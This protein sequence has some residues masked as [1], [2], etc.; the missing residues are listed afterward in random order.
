MTMVVAW[1]VLPIVLSLLSLGCGLLLETVSGMRLPGALLLPGGFIVISLA[2]QFAHMSDLTAVLQTPLVI[3]MALAGYALSRPWKRFQLDRWLAGAAAGVYAVFAAPVVLS[4]HA[5][6]TGYIKLDDTAIYQAMLDRAATHAYN[7]VGLPLGTYK[8]VLYQGYQFGYPLGSFLPLDIGH[9]LLRVDTMWLWQPYLTFLAVLIALGLYQLTSGLVQSRALRA[10]VAF[11]GTQAA[12][13]YGYS[14]WGGVKELF[15]PGVILFA[16]CLVPRLKDGGPRQV[17]PLGVASAA[18]IGGL[19]VGGGIWIL[20]M[21]VAGLTLLVLYRPANEVPATIGVYVL[22]AGALAIPILSV[23]L[24]RLRHLGNGKFLK[25][26]ETGNLLRP[27]NWKQVF[28]IWPSGDFRNNPTHASLTYL[29]IAV[30]ALAATFAVVA[31][32]RR[33]RW[34]VV[35]AL[36]TALFSCLVYV[37]S[38][39]S[40]V[41]GKALASSSPLVLGVA[42]VGIAVFIDGRRRVEGG[43]A[44][45]AIG[46]VALAAIAGGVLWSNTTQYHAALLAPSSRLMELETIGRKFAGKGPALLPE[47][48]PYAARHFLRDL[49]AEGA[50]ELRPHYI[51]LRGIPKRYATQG[52]SPDVD[53]FRLRGDRRSADPAARVGLIDYR[54]LIIRRTGSSSRPPSIYS[55]RFSGR[56]YDVWQRPPRLTAIIKHLSLGSRFQPAGVLDCAKVMDLAQQ[57]SAANGLLAA[58][59]RPEAIVFEDGHVGVPTEYG[60][61]GEPDPTLLY[62]AT[63]AYERVLHFTVPS[64]GRYNLW[65][66]GSFSSTLTMY[67]DGREVGQQSNQTE[68]PGNLLSFGSAELT[69]GTHTLGIRHSGPDLGPGSAARQPFGLGPFVIAQPINPNAITYVQP[70]AAHSLCGKSL[71]W[72]EAL[73][74]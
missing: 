45:A 34:E 69:R 72:V 71:D 26:G 55:L 47:Y 11:F 35:V 20:P 3:A 37:L 10:C 38:A 1:I 42:L 30:V 15:L 4:G 24:Y 13:M 36:A 39:A 33:G 60:P 28:G 70:N 18:V 46:G 59:P 62:R 31:A 29:L 64:A 7:V 48:E 67:I 19:S 66:G 32:W 51:Y 25:G 16:A 6:F 23:S 63:N 9:T 61:Y 50:T 53:E 40:W 49:G 27:L 56:Y 22:T 74:G 41:A 8:S 68:W 65:V 21:L 44:L 58:F 5:T 17:I 54:T 73:R 43:V 14:L 2:T 12:L 52:A 57:A